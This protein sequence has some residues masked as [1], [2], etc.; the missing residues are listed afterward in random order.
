MYCCVTAYQSLASGGGTCSGINNLAKCIDVVDS[1]IIKSV[2]PGRGGR[3]NEVDYEPYYYSYPGISAQ[4]AVPIA[5]CCYTGD[6]AA[7]GCTWFDVN[8]IRGSGGNG[9]F[10]S[11]YLA[12]VPAQ[13]PG[14]GGGGPVGCD[15]SGALIGTGGILGG[16][17]GCCGSGGI[18]GG[19]GWCGTPGTGM[20]VIYWN[21]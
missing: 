3:G 4:L 17:G 7:S 2:R 19:E 10:T 15:G 5:P 6:S 8:Q 13:P 20:V 12:C 1:S 14:P 21:A 11:A 9:T 18:G 16:G